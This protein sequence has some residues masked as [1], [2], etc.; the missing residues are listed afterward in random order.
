VSAALAEDTNLHPTK[1]GSLFE[2]ADELS[3]NFIVPARDLM[4][5]AQGDDGQ[6]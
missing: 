2:I 4:L 6:D 5:I 3:P 1:T